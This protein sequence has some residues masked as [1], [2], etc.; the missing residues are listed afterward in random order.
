MTNI[1]IENDMGQSRV[2]KLQEALHQISKMT[3]RI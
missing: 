1:E 2:D 3:S